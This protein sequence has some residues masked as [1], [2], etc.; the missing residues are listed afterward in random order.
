M[1]NG[2]TLSSQL[3]FQTQ[4]LSLPCSSD[5]P[6]SIASPYTVRLKRSNMKV[7]LVDYSHLLFQL[8]RWLSTHCSFVLELINFSTS[9]WFAHIVSTISWSWHCGPPCNHVNDCVSVNN[10]ARSQGLLGWQSTERIQI[11]LHMLDGERFS[12]Q[13]STRE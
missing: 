4:S 13:P 9:F 1:G 11:F 3:R 7:L 6:G 5:P 10:S 2:G 8:D 12:L